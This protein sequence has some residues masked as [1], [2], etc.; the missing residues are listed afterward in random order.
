M[1]ALGG[2]AAIG[3]VIGLVIRDTYHPGLDP[4]P[5]V[6]YTLVLAG[7]GAG[8]SMLRKHPPLNGALIGGALGWIL[9]AWGGADLGDGSIGTSLIAALVP[10]LLIG[11]RLGMSTNPTTAH[12]STSTTAPGR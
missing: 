11:A 12:G 6:V 9:G 4:L 7:I 10:A 5:I 1:I 2:S 8:L 3:V